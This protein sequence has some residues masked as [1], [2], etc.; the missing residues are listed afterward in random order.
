MIHSFFDS[1]LHFCPQKPNDSLTKQFGFRHVVDSFLLLFP[2]VCPRANCSPCCSHCRSFLK[3]NHE[4]FA[5]TCC[6]LQTS[7]GS[8]LLLG[9]S[10]S[11]FRSF[12]NKKRAN[13]TKNQRANSQPWFR[14]PF[15]VITLI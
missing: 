2:F 12:T 10:E 9:K 7:N 3:S 14:S 1:R 13:R 8:N 11:L 6:S 5:H 4:Q 15:F